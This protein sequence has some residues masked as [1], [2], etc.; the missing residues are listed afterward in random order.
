[1]YIPAVWTTQEAYWISLGKIS[2]Q[3]YIVSFLKN[4]LLLIMC[5]WKEGAGA[6]TGHRHWIFDLLLWPPTFPVFKKSEFTYLGGW[7]EKVIQVISNC[8]LL[9][10]NHLLI[11]LFVMF[12]SSSI[13]IQMFWVIFFSDSVLR[14]GLIKLRLASNSL[15]NQGRPWTPDP[16]KWNY[17][18]D[19]PIIQWHCLTV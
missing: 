7:C 10:L 12:L 5:L 6:H 16:S 13:I 9:F 18:Y 11:N 14:Q 1:M 15:C 3:F 2:L 4:R 19:F 17:L 8:Q